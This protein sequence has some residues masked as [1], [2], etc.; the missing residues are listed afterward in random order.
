MVWLPH[1]PKV[2]ESLSIKLGLERIQALLSA[3]DNPEKKMP[4]AIHIAGTN[5]KGST[6]AFAKSILEQAGLKVHVFTSPHLE[7]FNERIVLAGEEITDNYLFQVSEECRIVS[8]KNN[9]QVSFFEGITAA[10]FLAFSRVKADVVILET[11][12][13]GRL[14]ATNV[15]ESPL[16][17]IITPISYDHTNVLG[18][19]LSK[20]A[21]EKCGIMRN[22]I[23]CVVSMQPVE[24]KK[25]IIKYAENLGTPLI[26]FEYDYGVFLENNMM[27]YSSKDF[28]ITTN[29]PSLP[30]DHQFINAAGAIAAIKSIYGDK[31]TKEIVEKGITKATWK[32]RL[33][34]IT[35]GR[36]RNKLNKD[37]EIWL[38]CAHNDAGAQVFGSWLTRQPSVPTYLIFSMTRNRDVNSFL[39]HINSTFEKIVCSDIHSEP[40]GY[41][42]ADIPSLINDK[43]IQKICEIVTSVE[44]GIDLIARQNDSDSKKRIVIAG[45]MYLV[46]DFLIA[47][48]N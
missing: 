12:L 28:D 47:N 32:G 7:R 17:T 34:K 3:L 31:I 19:T 4:P 43:N 30:G 5:G 24:A 13:G 48:K 45:S 16:V 1:W 6:T 46:S 11:G 25:T 15:L 10:A 18:D 26:M 8:E 29:P 27:R 23:P 14:D 44:S 40:L 41:R 9:I 35:S 37:W 42:G 39:S 22:N 38:D 21:T 36:L 33:Q 2:G 20:I